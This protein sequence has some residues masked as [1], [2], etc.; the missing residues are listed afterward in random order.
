[1]LQVWPQGKKNSYQN[2]NE[3]TMTCNTELMVQNSKLDSK[4]RAEDTEIPGGK[5]IIVVGI[6]YLSPD[7]KAI[8]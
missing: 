6:S 2:A 5:E 7:F 8:L 3:G 1:M 4:A